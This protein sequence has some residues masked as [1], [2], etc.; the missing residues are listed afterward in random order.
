M[1]RGATRFCC[2]SPRRR[3]RRARP[4]RVCARESRPLQGAAQR[5][6]RQRATED[7][8]RQD[9]EVRVESATPCDRSAVSQSLSFQYFTKQTSLSARDCLTLASVCLVFNKFLLASDLATS[10]LVNLQ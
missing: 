5:D 4:A 2:A 1:G 9:S 10:I 3:C 8:D 7:C 6:L